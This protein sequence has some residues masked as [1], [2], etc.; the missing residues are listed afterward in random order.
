MLRGPESTAPS[1][2]RSRS[3]SS[4][5]GPSPRSSPT[6]GVAGS[7]TRRPL[8]VIRLRLTRVRRSMSLISAT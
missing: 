5:G 6:G 3:T 7:V 8:R 4:W 1:D 2:P